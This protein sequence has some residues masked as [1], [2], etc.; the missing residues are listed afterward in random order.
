MEFMKDLV[1]GGIF[2]GQLL[3]LSYERFR[4]YFN[5]LMDYGEEMGLLLGLYFWL[6]DKDY[7]LFYCY[8]KAYDLC[9]RNEGIR[10]SS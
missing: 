7:C 2:Y 4:L 3:G 5:G 8:N 6:V 9:E 1:W 10:D